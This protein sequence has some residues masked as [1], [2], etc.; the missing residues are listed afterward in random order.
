MAESTGA[1]SLT[2]ELSSPAPQ[3]ITVTM[4][5][6]STAA[7]PGATSPPPA[8][9]TTIAQGA[10]TGNLGVT[11]NDD[12]I[13]EGDEVVTATLRLPPVRSSAHPPRSCSPSRTTTSPASSCPP[14]SRPRPRRAAASPSAT[15]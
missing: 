3:P 11:I 13:V 6:S 12:D 2:V 4:Q 1:V 9:P 5:L 8:A 14:A 7:I 15:P 10:D